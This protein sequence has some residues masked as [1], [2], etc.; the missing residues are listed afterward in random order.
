MTVRPRRSFQKYAP[1]LKSIKYSACVHCRPLSVSNMLCQHA[2]SLAKST[3]ENCTELEKFG[4]CLSIG[5]VRPKR[6]IV[7]IS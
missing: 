7:Y 5:C 4:T 6:T 3:R 2:K 1:Q